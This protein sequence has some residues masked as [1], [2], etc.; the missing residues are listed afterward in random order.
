MR[1]LTLFAVIAVCSLA[2]CL[3][4]PADESPKRTPIQQDILRQLDDMRPELVAVNQDIWTYAELGLQEH[5]S[6]S[7]LAGLLKKAGFRVKEGVSDMPTAFVAEYG[8]GKPIIGILAEYDA[9]PELSQ[10]AGTATR[11]AIAGSNAGH[12]CGHC[13]WAPP[14]SGRR[15]PS[16]TSSTSTIYRAP[17]VCTVRRPRRPSSARCS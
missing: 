8:S 12:G 3:A 9:L 5:R 10:Q 6:A 17:F 16:R 2:A 15:S 11:Q 4:A 1:H 13:A 14:P 7:R